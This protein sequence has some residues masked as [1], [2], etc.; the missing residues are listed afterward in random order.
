MLLFEK[1]YPSWWFDWNIE[2]LRFS[3][4]LAAYVC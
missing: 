2:L 1:K 3:N 4:R